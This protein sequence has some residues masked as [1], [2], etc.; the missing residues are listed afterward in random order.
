MSRV[1]PRSPGPPAAPGGRQRGCRREGEAHASAFGLRQ[2]FHP[3]RIGRAAPRA[4]P[5]HDDAIRDHGTGRRYSVQTIDVAAGRV[6]TIRVEVPNGVLHVN[7]GPWAEVF[8]DG[9]RVGE[10][11][12]AN[13]AVRVK[14]QQ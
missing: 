2:R 6:A 13:L 3:A 11:P 5:R 8:V 10:T 7:A 12:I 1:R 4:E 9:R 14:P